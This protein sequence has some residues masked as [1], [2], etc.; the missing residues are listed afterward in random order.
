MPRI[1]AIASFASLRDARRVRGAVRHSNRLTREIPS[2][3][4]ARQHTGRTST[5]RVTLPRSHPVRHRPAQGTLTREVVIAA[6]LAEIDRRGLEDFSLRKLAKALGVYPTAVTYYVR[7]RNQLLAAVAALAF[8]DTLPPAF[9]NSWQSDVRETFRRFRQAIRRHPNIAPLIG[10][11]LVANQS[12]DLA[13]VE[14]LL[15]T[16]V[17]AGFSG[18]RLVGAYNTLVAA[19]VGFTTQEFAPLPTE[20]RKA[21]QDEVRGRL[22]GVRSLEYPILARN[23]KHLANQAFILRWQNGSEAP[24]EAAFE[25]CID[26]VIGGL[27][28]LAARR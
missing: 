25:S 26:T 15:A 2:S 20:D 6:A 7:D 21:W 24:L 23:M 28:R 18:R 5:R 27:E 11:Q 10:T 9:P 3:M 1:P 16:L 13:F 12:V 17:R 8:A 19:L 22:R 4:T 14:R